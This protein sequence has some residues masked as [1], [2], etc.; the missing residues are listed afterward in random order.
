MG[1]GVP[2]HKPIGPG[3]AVIP[4]R[5]ES[6]EQ[7]RPA[8][9]EVAAGENDPAPPK[10]LA[11]DRRAGKRHGSTRS[12]ERGPSPDAARFDGGCQVGAQGAGQA[13]RS[14]DVELAGP[15][16]EHVGRRQW[17]RRVLEN[18]LDQR[19]GQPGV[20]LQQQGD[21]TRHHGR[22]NGGTAQHHQRAAALLVC[23]D[24]LGQ[25][26]VGERQVGRP[27]HRAVVGG[28][29]TDDPVARRHQ[30]GL[31][32]IV[33]RA[34]AGAADMGAACG[35]ARTEGGDDVVGA[36]Q[37]SL[38]VAGPDRDHRGVVPRRTDAAIA[39]CTTVG[40]AVVPGRHDDRDPGCRCASNR[41][42]QRVGSPGLRG[43][44]RQAEVHHPDVVFPGVVD[45]PVDTS[46]HV[47]ELAQALVVQHLHVVERRAGGD[48]GGLGIPPGVVV[49]T[50]R[51]TGN[52][53]TVSIGVDGSF[54]PVVQSRLVFLA[55]VAPWRH[56]L[57][58]IDTGRPV[59]DTTR[60]HVTDFQDVDAA[61]DTA[62]ARLVFEQRMFP[63]QTR[64]EHGDADAVAVQPGVGAGERG[65][66][67]AHRRSTA[68]GLDDA[69]C[70]GQACA[71]R[72]PVGRDSL[73]VGSFGEIVHRV[74]R[75]EDRQGVDRQVTHVHRTTL[76]EDV[77]PQRGKLRVG[78][79]GDHQD[80]DIQ[81]PADA[82]GPVRL[83]RS[84]RTDHLTQIGRDLA[85]R[86]RS[87]DSHRQA[88]H[89]DE[90]QPALA[91]PSQAQP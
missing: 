3:E 57:R 17:L 41:T 90:N 76:G 29:C 26:R 46:Q 67:G 63:H 1:D 52:V 75:Q 27:L 2:V 54:V 33:E 62:A 24:H 72:G 22:R 83:R 59:L 65:C 61:A 20:G 32:E 25:L 47:T 77:G 44:R 86:R 9:D 36:R 43:I 39:L 4:D 7:A 79:V 71:H 74:R 78:A 48:A 64:V 13:H 38:Q 6:R 28:Q 40:P 30:I 88:E 19:R 56:G 42:R 60:G 5:L 68:H 50:G 18:G 37:R 34:L 51:D 8:D 81:H 91:G 23:T 16:L 15:L 89:Q 58:Q 87:R 12:Q 55:G 31:E 69:G 53:G 84:R 85:L 66:S 45:D 35:A 49:A 10:R 70:H 80:L 14:L 73:D 21:R 11:V 82:P